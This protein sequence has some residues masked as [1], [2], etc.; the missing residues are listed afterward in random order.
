MEKLALV[1]I[2][3]ERADFLLNLAE[4]VVGDDDDPWA[5]VH[6]MALLGAGLG[7]LREA[8]EE[9]DRAVPNRP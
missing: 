7:A 9:I 1:R 2:T 4:S 5:K 8:V 3:L 6:L